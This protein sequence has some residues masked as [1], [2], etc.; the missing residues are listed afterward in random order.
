MIVSPR[1]LAVIVALLLAVAHQPSAAAGKGEA[2]AQRLCD[3]LHTLPA[4]RKQACCG[5]PGASLAAAC[6]QET[7]A[8]VRRAT[9]SLDTARIEGCAAEA[10]TQLEGCG[11]VTPLLPDLPA[12]CVGVI[13]GKVKAGGA[14]YSSLECGDGLYCR[15]V[16][17]TNAGL[18]RPPQEAGAA[19][20]VP[21][22]NLSAFT[23]AK[24][25]PRHPSCQGRCVKSKCLPLAPAGGACVSS[26]LCAAGLN[27]IAGRCENRPLPKVA[28]SCAGKTECAPGAYCQDGKCVALK[29]QGESCRL[30][31]ECRG[32]SCDKAPG[33][34]AGTCGSP[35]GRLVSQ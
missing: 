28:E 26:A 7:T 13:G 27:C 29:G 10:A 19:C 9:V 21:A 35:C 1:R 5:A 6:V 15:G 17:P 23:R 32:L 25:D 11:W 18:C 33:A 20:E 22:D 24:D 3:A 8:A 16:S 2:L 34:K 30:P 4:Q 14:C 31:F 12:A